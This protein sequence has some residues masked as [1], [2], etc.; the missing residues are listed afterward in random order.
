MAPPVSCPA[1]VVLN[2]RNASNGISR[3]GVLRGPA[4]VTLD[5]PHLRPPSQAPPDTPR[6]P[7]MPAVVT[8]RRTKPSNPFPSP[9]RR[10]YR[11][12]ERSEQRKPTF[13]VGDID[14]CHPLQS[15]LVE[16]K[17]KTPRNPVRWA[18]LSLRWMISQRIHFK[19][20]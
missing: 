7:P 16:G 18:L 14:R 9:N 17:K 6:Q 11:D 13:G 4:A 1:D 19:D 2:A 12:G 15:G 5:L 10:I 20:L 3:P 8:S